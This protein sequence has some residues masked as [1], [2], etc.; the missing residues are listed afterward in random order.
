MQ[1]CGRRKKPC[2]RKRSAPIH[3]RDGRVTGAVIVFHDA[4]ESRAMVRQIAYQAQ[5][6]FLTGLPNR[7]LLTTRL[8]Q[9]IGQTHRHRKQIALL[10]LDLD[11][12]KHINP[13]LGHAIGDELLQSVAGRLVASVRA[14]DTVSRQGGDEFMVLLTEIESPQDAAHVAKKCWPH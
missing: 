3:D 12:F 6:D 5:H 8:S 14:T 4:T 9:A 10:V 11:Y 2:S 13:S 7:T 1:R